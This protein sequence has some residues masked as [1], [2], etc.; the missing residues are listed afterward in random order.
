[1]GPTVLLPLRRKACWG[2][3]FRP[4]NPTASAGCEHANLG[5]KGQHATF[6]PSKPRCTLSTECIKHHEFNSPDILIF[7]SFV[8]ICMWCN[9]STHC[10]VQS[11]IK[12]SIFESVQ[13]A[14][15]SIDTTDK[16]LVEF[17][18]QNADI[19]W[20]LEMFRA[21]RKE[22]TLYMSGKGKVIPLQA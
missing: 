10:P 5:T 7:P 17:Y 9:D 1:M 13:V 12:N 2:F 21:S 22:D 19:Y 3:F 14:Q 20:L 16:M 15:K 18:W 8:E 6:R 11:K 4:K